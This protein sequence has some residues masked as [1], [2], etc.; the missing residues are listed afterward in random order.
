MD[1]NEET[2]P[3]YEIWIIIVAAGVVAVVLG[4][5]LLSFLMST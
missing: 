1:G 4:A 3:K 5:L 2:N